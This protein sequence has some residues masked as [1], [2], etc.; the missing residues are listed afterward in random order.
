MN[1]RLADERQLAGSLIDGRYRVQGVL[2]VGGMSTVYSAHDERLG[3]DVAVKVISPA[4]GA[5]ESFLR[6]FDSEARASARLAHP[7]VVAVLDRSSEQ[8]LPYIVFE[9]VSGETLRS[10]I[11]AE[12][13][14]PQGAAL[15]LWRQLV[16][17]LGHAH[18]AGLIH[19]DVKPENVLVTRD[20]TAKLTDFGLARAVAE[21][22]TTATI[23]GTARYVAPE[24][25]ADSRS[26]ERSDLYSAGILLF[27]MLTGSAPFEGANPINVA[28][29]HVHRDVPAPSTREPGIHPEVD[30]L[31]TWCCAKDPDERPQS[32]ADLLR[33]AEHIAGILP[34][35]RPVPPRPAVSPSAGSHAASEQD[36][37]PTTS[38]ATRPLTRLGGHRL[39]GQASPTTVLGAH[40]RGP[41]TPPA[42]RAEATSPEEGPRQDFGRL[43][44]D[45]DTQAFPVPEADS[46]E[47]SEPDHGDRPSWDEGDWGPDEP[48]HAE[49][50]WPAQASPQ[51]SRRQARRDARRQL[52]QD[53]RPLRSVRPSGG[54]GLTA[55]LVIILAMAVLALGIA[56]FVSGPAVFPLQSGAVQLGTAWTAV[57]SLSVLP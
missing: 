12:A 1:P 18:E 23:M 8:S 30:S 22:K 42:P 6:R 17:A 35:D 45:E 28:Y 32:A 4:L 2:G 13:P 51:P 47:R 34:P 50:G 21:A 41:A 31:V 15:R 27:E 54:S 19:R 7:N 14:M 38:L 3:R 43:S 40:P 11:T 24:T 16:E 20:G 29:A 39:P 10:A 52:A 37:L 33:E 46:A 57:I 56:V 36:G 55:A 25:I 5:D 48:V 26:D 53:R 44:L 9:R 49:A